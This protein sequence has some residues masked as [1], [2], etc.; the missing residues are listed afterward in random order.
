MIIQINTDHNI[1]ENEKMDLY[2][3]TLIADSLK[4]YSEHITRLEVHFSDQNG[5]KEGSK[6]KKCLLEARI[7]G[8]QP[9][10]V[11]ATASTIEE[12]LNNAID[13]MTALLKTAIEQMKSHR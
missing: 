1:S 5:N 12:A 10:V 13:K 8:R 7:E 4:N 6:D 3:K 11:T 2:F 9:N